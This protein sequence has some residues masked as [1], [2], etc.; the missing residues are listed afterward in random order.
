MQHFMLIG[1]SEGTTHKI[2][3][4][5]HIHLFWCWSGWS[6]VGMMKC[7]AVSDAAEGSYPCSISSSC[8]SSHSER[9]KQEQLWCIFLIKYSYKRFAELLIV[10]EV[11]W[12]Q[13]WNSSTWMF[14]A[15]ISAEAKGTQK[16][17]ILYAFCSF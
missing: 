16:Y 3:M 2:L 6:Y 10:S 7:T 4:H 1:W 5:K 8:I 13:Q 11:L 12:W 14:Y 9:G 17:H 15:E